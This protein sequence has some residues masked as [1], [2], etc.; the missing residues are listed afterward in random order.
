MWLQSRCYSYPVSMLST[1]F[2]PETMTPILW[3]KYK[4]KKWFAASESAS[5]TNK[6]F[7]HQFC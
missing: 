1:M 2:N 7:G 4:E 5:E 3:T 6:K